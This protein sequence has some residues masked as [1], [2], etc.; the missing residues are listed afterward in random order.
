MLVERGCRVL[1]ADLDPQADATRMIL[2]EDFQVG[3]WPNF[4]ILRAIRPVVSGA[5]DVSQ[6]PSF[7]FVNNLY[8]IP[9]DLALSTFEEDFSEAWARCSNRDEAALRITAALHRAI[10]VLALR[11]HFDWVLIDVGSNLGAINRAAL[12]ASEFVIVPLLPDSFS[13]QSLESLGPRLREWQEAWTVLRGKSPAGLR[14]PTGSMTPIGYVVLERGVRDSR[15]PKDNQRWVDQIPS[16]FRRAVLGQ[17]VIPGT[18]AEED[19]YCLATIK[20]Y[21]SLM[22][23]AM[24]ARKPVFALKPSDGA[25]GA[26][27]EAVRR[28]YEDFENLVL[29][30]E[31]QTGPGHPENRAPSSAT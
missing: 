5:G 16:T 14:L 27:G 3:L 6:V 11:E 1:V 30:I 17:P 22:P 23:M 21:R 8:V 9:G 26:H 24:E 13:L 10:E 7:E 15:P 19:P 25:I 4:T 20:H 29:R 2:T 12:I 31:S 18:E 28:S